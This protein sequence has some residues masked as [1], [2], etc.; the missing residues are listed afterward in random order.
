MELVPAGRPLGVQ[1]T[2]E[3]VE[4]LA[5]LDGVVAH[6]LELGGDGL[7]GLEERAV[8]RLVGAV[9]MGVQAGQQTG[10]PGRAGGGLDVCVT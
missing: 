7:A 9:V 5:H 1:K 2:L 3:E 4:V 10:A 6:G 8:I